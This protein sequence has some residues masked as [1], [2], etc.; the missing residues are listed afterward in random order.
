MIIYTVKSG[1]TLFN[2]SKKYG[3]SLEQIINVNALA[4]PEKLLI[5][6]S[7]IIPS[8]YRSYF[9]QNGDSIFSIAKYYSVNEQDIIKINSLSA[10]YTIYSGQELLIPPSLLYTKKEI[11]TNGYA[12]ETITEQTINNIGRYLT[13]LSVFSYKINGNGVLTD[14]N[15]SEIIKACRKNRTVPI[16]VVTNTGNTGGFN[17]N[18]VAKVL[19]DNTVSNTLINNIINTAKQKGY[20]GINI[21]FEY[22]PSENRQ[23]Y[24]MF[25]EKLYKKANLENLIVSTAVA[26]KTRSNQSGLLYEAHDYKQHGENTDFVILM[27]YEWGYLYGPPMAVSPINE[28]EKVLRYAITEVNG[29]NLMMSLPNYAYNWTLPFKRGRAAEVL[30]LNQAF[31]LALQQNAEIEFNEASATPFY[32]YSENSFNHVVWFDDARSFYEKAELLEK[33]NLRGVS[34]WSVNNFFKPVWEILDNMYTIKKLL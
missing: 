31:N 4:Q 6:Q 19:T 24:N 26:P 28:I 9:V 8:P 11:E 5:G 27:T 3:V 34:F 33:Y 29:N 14:I 1:D 16:M 13:Y 10:P 20:G 23:N 22:I 15:D 32:N 30:N 25:L 18:T 12:Y 21:D 2:I 17:S 7:L